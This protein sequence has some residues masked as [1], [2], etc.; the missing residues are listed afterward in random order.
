LSKKAHKAGMADLATGILHNLGNVLNSVNISAGRIAETL[1]NSK[2]SSFKKANK[3]LDEYQDNFEKFIIEDPR[4]KQLLN[5]YLKLEEP[6]LEEYREIQKH[7]NRLDGKVQLMTEI[8]EAQQKYAGTGVETQETSLE[9]LIDSVLVFQKGFI[10]QQNL[11]IQKDIGSTDPVIVQRTKLLHLLINIFEN[12]MEAM[13]ELSPQDKQIVI[14]TWEDEKNVCLS[15]I[16]DGIGIHKKD[17]DKI[18]T[19]DFSIKESSHG[20]GLDSS[21]HYISEIGCKIEVKSEGKGKGA[22]F[23]LIFPCLYEK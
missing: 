3:L 8:I 2:F 22:T 15:I 1:K 9:K 7:S 17:F 14:K 5:Y 13:S 12:A 18:F 20:F 19:Q 16:V 23:I 21:A 4:G 6:M 11:K 10:E